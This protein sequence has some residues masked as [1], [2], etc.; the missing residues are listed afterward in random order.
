MPISHNG[1]ISLQNKVQRAKQ[2]GITNP[3]WR[4]FIILSLCLLGFQNGQEDPTAND[5]KSE[6][7]ISKVPNLKPKRSEV[8]MFSR[9]V[10]IRLYKTTHVYHPFTAVASLCKPVRVAKTIEPST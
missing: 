1:A 6:S 4:S 2:K 10:K 9:S 7:K 5:T 8:L 3:R